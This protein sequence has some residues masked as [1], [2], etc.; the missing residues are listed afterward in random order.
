MIDATRDN[1][2]QLLERVKNARET[3][4]VVEALLQTD[5]RVFAR[6]T[7]GIYREPASA[8]RELIANAFDADA[9]EVRVDTDAPRFSR[10]TVRDDGRGLSE[11]ALTHV[12]CHIGGS[13]KRTE[14]GAKYNVASKEDSSKSFSG[15]ELIGKLGIGLF[16]V[17]QLTHHLVIVTKVK[18]E[19]FRRVCDIVLMPQSDAAVAKPDSNGKFVTG[20]AQINTIPADDPETQGTEITLYDIRPFVRESLQSRALWAAI[21]PEEADSDSEDEDA[22]QPQD[23][24]ATDGDGF[25]EAPAEPSFHIGRVSAKDPELL[26]VQPNLPWI[27]DDSPT[28]KFR[29]LVDGV[30]ALSFTT[31]ERIKLADVLDSY[32]RTIWTLALS[33]PL[34]YIN[35][36]PFELKR[37]DAV[38]TFALKNQGKRPRATEIELA[39]GQSLGEAVGMVT[40]SVQG[41]LPF[42]VFVDGIELKRPLVYPLQDADSEPLLFVGRIRSEMNSLPVGF[43][44]GPIEFEAY[45][46]WVHKITPVEHNGVLI[47]IHGASGILFDEHF[48]K[49]QTSELTRLRQLTAEIYVV[50][51]LDAALNIDRESFNIAHPHYQ[52]LKKWVHH[53]LRQVMSRHKGLSS[54]V[55]SQRLDSDLAVA[56]DRVHDLVRRQS[57]KNTVND[58]KLVE[59][60]TMFEAAPL[61][62]DKEVV[63][64]SRSG[65]KPVTKADKARNV[66][67]EEQ[68][69]AVAQIL[70]EFGVWNQVPV[71]D[72]DELLKR[73]VEVFSVNIKK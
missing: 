58:V 52:F 47:R 57:K 11:E 44:G 39:S 43:S 21:K 22:L 9:T 56:I 7:D 32:L 18:G 6:I 50:Q 55:V 38:K 14:K 66:L 65:V 5:D 29:K 8:L 40:K 37:E 36:H 16:S 1:E 64:A 70:E 67:F 72:R 51:G 48:L 62:F 24:E 28:E 27:P 13:L 25:Y 63:F 45:F 10:I 34:P 26:L 46:H 71:G 61:T 69:V 30:Q 15:R 20:R 3:G 2:K 59:R 54:A 60:S 49:Y 53:A 42:N 23:E 4:A 17:S 19:K 73:I 41:K 68:I 33:V 31:V 12:I 35:K